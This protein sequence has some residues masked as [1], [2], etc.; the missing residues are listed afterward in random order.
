[1]FQSR[2]FVHST[3]LC[4]VEG[5]DLASRLSSDYRVFLSLVRSLGRS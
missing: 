3:I 2:K 1:M 4:V 5:V